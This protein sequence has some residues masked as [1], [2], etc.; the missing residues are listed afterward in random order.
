MRRDVDRERRILK[1][2]A[3]GVPAAQTSRREGISPKTVYNSRYRARKTL[4][5]SPYTDKPAQIAEIR[6]AA[7]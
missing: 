2:W 7:W 5:T 6:A 4:L 1:D 3:A